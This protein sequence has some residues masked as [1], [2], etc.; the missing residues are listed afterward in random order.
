MQIAL[1]G[2]SFNPP[3]LG[4]AMVASWVLWSGLADEVWW[5]PSFAHPFAKSMVGFDQRLGLV[6]QLTDALGKG[7]RCCGVEAD[8]PTPS[9]TIDVLDALSAR[10]PQASFRLVLG[11][12][13]LPDLPRWSQSERLLA[14][15][16]PVVVG[17]D[18]YDNPEG[19][20]VFPGLSSTEVRELASSGR[21]V[22][23]LV[24]EAIAT[25]VRDLY[26]GSRGGPKP[27][28]P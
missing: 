16:A 7:H 28:H 6:Q 1:Y 5:T 17:R 20:V 14:E 21:P 2:G 19:T 24:H 25:Q 15:Y 11:S 23:H 22:A 12:D 18:G 3:H 8:L 13:N 9:Y 10:H 27:I 26:S 4:H